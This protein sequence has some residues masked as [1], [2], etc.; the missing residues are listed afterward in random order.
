MRKKKFLYFAAGFG[1]IAT[2]GLSVLGVKAALPTT[3]TECEHVGNHYE[4]VG[5]TQLHAHSHLVAMEPSAPLSLC[6]YIYHQS[7]FGV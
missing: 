5:A 7:Q 2:L 3:A 4:A 6:V 1:A